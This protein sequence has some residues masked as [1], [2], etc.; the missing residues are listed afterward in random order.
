[1]D[2]A[3]EQFYNLVETSNFHALLKDPHTIIKT[4]P[5]IPSANHPFYKDI[6]AANIPKNKNQDPDFLLYG[7]PSNLK[8]ISSFNFKL[9]HLR[10]M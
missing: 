4:E 8:S 5:F 9:N 2:L 6:V 7:L 10:L 3:L 1:M